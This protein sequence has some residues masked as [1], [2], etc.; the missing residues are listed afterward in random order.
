MAQ[1]AQ[2]GGPGL[3]PDPREATALAKVQ[4]LIAEATRLKNEALE[5][6]TSQ[7]PDYDD[8]PVRS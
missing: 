3:F 2:P 7:L 6:Q 8:V 5:P 4:R 1:P